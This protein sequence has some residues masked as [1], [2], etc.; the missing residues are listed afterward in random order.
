MRR[1]SVNR[2]RELITLYIKSFQILLGRHW[3]EINQCPTSTVGEIVL[4][5]SKGSVKCCVKATN[6]AAGRRSC[7]AD[8]TRPA[9]RSLFTLSAHNPSSLRSR[10]SGGRIKVGYRLVTQLYLALPRLQEIP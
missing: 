2:V 6:Q 4:A 1:I 3:I 10:E 8:G 9:V 7:R 5:D